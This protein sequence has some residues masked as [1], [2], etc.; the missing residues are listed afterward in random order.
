VAYEER[1]LDVYKE[2]N[3]L[4]QKLDDATET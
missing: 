4:A 3:I 1:I 2:D